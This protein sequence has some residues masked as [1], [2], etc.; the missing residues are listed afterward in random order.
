DLMFL[1]HH[2][3]VYVTDLKI[4]ESLGLIGV[5]SVIIADNIISPGNPPYLKYVRS[6]VEEK[7]RN[8]RKAMNGSSTVDAGFSSTAVGLYKKRI[9]FDKFDSSLGNPNFRSHSE[10]LEGSEPTGE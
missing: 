3:P 1:D 9:S 4:S 5:G 2:K 7:R 10:M 6:S 8:V